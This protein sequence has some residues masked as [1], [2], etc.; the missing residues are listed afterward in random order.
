MRFNKG[1]RRVLHLRKNN[2]TH[3]Y[4]LG[5]DQLER[6]STEKGL[7]VLVD[8]RLAISQQCALGAKN[9]SGILR[10]INKNMASRSRDVIL[11]FYCALV[12]SHLEY[13]IPFWD[14]Q[15]KKDR[16]PLEKVQRR[17][18]KMTKGLQHLPYE[19]RLGD[20][21]L[22]SLEETDW[23]ILPMHINI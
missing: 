8:N 15:F 11:L 5:D 14:P 23:G 22:F 20:L 1:K 7:V 2:F 4:R 18:T 17:A 19:E 3:Q 6:S 12:R 21:G 16:E 13:C 10:C 9:A